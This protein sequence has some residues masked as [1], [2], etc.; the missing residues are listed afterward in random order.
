MPGPPA[1]Q[2]LRRAAGA[3]HVTGW[4]SKGFE[5][6]DREPGSQDGEPGSQTLE[7]LGGLEKRLVLGGGGTIDGFGY[8]TKTLILATF[9]YTISSVP[10]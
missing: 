5:H 4:G 6:Q 3:I 7:Y 9:S 8:I 2:L 1:N 10:Q